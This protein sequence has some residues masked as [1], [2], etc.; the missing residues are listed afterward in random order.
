MA[1]FNVTFCK[2]YEAYIQIEAETA[3]EAGEMVRD[4][5]F[6]QAV[7]GSYFDRPDEEIIVGGYVMPDD[8][9]YGD[10]PLYEWNDR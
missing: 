6:S 1:I 9:E 5:D 10:D 3:E 4:G 2:E 7:D 8:E